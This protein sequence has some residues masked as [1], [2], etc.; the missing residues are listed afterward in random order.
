MRF[1][2]FTVADGL[3]TKLINTGD[4]AQA[5]L[6]VGAGEGIVQCEGNDCDVSDIVFKIDTSGET[7]VLAAID[8]G[9]LG[10]IPAF[11]SMEM[12]LP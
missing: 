12:L 2:V 6:N 3:I 10:D 8:P 5:V 11:T 9:Y 1:F 4:P 7:P